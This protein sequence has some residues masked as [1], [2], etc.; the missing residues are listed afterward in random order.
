MAK[1]K[2]AI[3]GPEST[4]K[5][6]LTA[7]L[8]EHYNSTLIP[9]M[10]R[11]YL[12]KLD[13]PYEYSDLLEIA[14]TQ[15]KTSEEIISSNQGNIFS[16]TS[17]LTIEIWSQDKFDKC[18]PWILN[19]IKKERFDLYLLCNVDTE[20]VFDKLREDKNRRKELF[21]IYEVLLKAY[22][23]EYKIISGLGKERLL[24]AIKAI[25]TIELYQSES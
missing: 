9:E 3:T 16:D 15:K 23:F 25:K 13:R 24:N 14:K 21:K 4:G 7:E 11:S 2:I 8:A 22:G 12:Q 19:Q 20:W 18:D 17:L 5:S 1:L 10:A 6:T